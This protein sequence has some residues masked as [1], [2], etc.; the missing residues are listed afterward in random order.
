MKHVAPAAEDTVNGPIREVETLGIED[1]TLD[2][3]EAEL[4]CSPT[5]NLDHR[6]G[7]VADDHPSGRSN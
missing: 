3:V 6:A 7:E 2:V 1:A 4:L 5:R